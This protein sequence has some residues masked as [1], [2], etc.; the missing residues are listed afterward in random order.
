MHPDKALYVALC[1]ELRRHNYYYYVL[2]SPIIEDAIYDR[3]LRSL[4]EMEAKN[5]MWVTSESP[6]QT[7][8]H[9]VYPG[10][11]ELVS[12]SLPM[13]SL[14]NV[15]TP[16]EA[17]DWTIDLHQDYG[18]NDV[19]V[20]VEWK[21]DGLSLDLLYTNGKLT[22]ASTRGDGT[23]G[24]NVTPNAL[25]IEG[26][27]RVLQTNEPVINV[28][29]EVVPRL[30]DYA[31]INRALA[32]AGKKTYAN[33]RNYAAGSLRLKDPKVTKDRKLVFVAHGPEHPYYNADEPGDW[34]K[35]QAWL[36]QNGFL[37]ADTGKRLG[38]KPGMTTGTPK[39]IEECRLERP[40]YPFE[41]DGLVFKVVSHRHRHEMGFTSRFPRWARAFKFPASKGTT[42]LL[43]V[44]RQVGRTGKLTPM[45][46]LVPI[47]LHGTTISNVTIHNLNELRQH[48][49]WAGC[50]VEIS[51]AGD[52]IPYLERRVTDI[53]EANPPVFYGQVNNCPCCDS[54]VV[55]VAGKTGSVT[56]YCPNAMCKARLEAHL[57][58]CAG[59]NVLNI[60][61]L[62]DELVVQLLHTGVVDGTRPLSLLELYE[63][64]FL[65]I[66]LSDRMAEKLTLAVKVAK[67]NLTLA[68]VITALGISNVAEGTAE[69]LARHCQSMDK[70]AMS[71][72][73][74]LMAI[75]GVGEVT[76]Q[77]V[78]EF[79]DQDRLNP[80]SV[81][82]HYVK[83]LPL[84]APE[85]IVHMFHPG[86][87]FV[88]TGSKFGDRSRKDIE[89]WLKGNGAKVSSEVRP[90]TTM[91]YCG[92]KYT[93]HK[94]E[95]A[96]EL[97]IPYQVWAEDGS[98]EV[99]KG[100][101]PVELG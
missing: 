77:S 38:N 33:P 47:H 19:E 57:I 69:D 76:A 68:R 59:R 16:D 27:P 86:T 10:H 51:R 58:Y 43:S 42:T 9:T 91:I 49:L 89:K 30:A 100:L 5:P 53:P 31:E 39:L 7:V 79:F 37:T 36:K 96:K 82:R 21:M 11:F 83:D 14:D 67:A 13:L 25:M 88:V 65:Q 56:E 64:D 32:E 78:F 61:G 73:D 35:D 2:D 8:G 72:V 90:S 1:E 23:T 6:T 54:E 80:S 41:V 87:T 84:P 34:Y 20:V 18:F 17:V 95:K 55:Y 70:L 92:T 93:K 12:R 40:N 29:G 63:Q 22:M 50:E 28:R 48:R 101:I 85:P 4:K 46:R 52:V 62:G 71:T 66:G 15:F 74:E 75:E 26:I 97:N 24:E 3:K 99:S 98:Y 45:A 94:L 44:D 81:W 60:K